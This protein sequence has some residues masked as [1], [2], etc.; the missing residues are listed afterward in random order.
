M[1][2]EKISFFTPVEYDDSAHKFREAVDNYFYLGGNKAKVTSIDTA[3]KCENVT[4]V[5]GDSSL[6]AKVLAVVKVVTYFTCIIPLVMLLAKAALRK[7]HQYTVLD[8]PNLNKESGVSTI[9]NVASNALSLPKE[10]EPSEREA[11]VPISTVAPAIPVESPFTGQGESAK[12]IAEPAQP[13]PQ[14]GPEP[15]QQANPM[16]V[17]EATK[18]PA[19][20]E[21]VPEKLEQPEDLEAAEPISED[22]EDPAA[23]S[24]REAEAR[25]ELEKEVD[26]AP[27]TLKKLQELLPK[28]IKYS[29]YGK[30]PEKEMLKEFEFYNHGQFYVVFKLKNVDFVFKIAYRKY[31]FGDRADLTAS[32]FANMVKAWEVCKVNNLAL[33]VIPHAKKLEIGDYELI[34]EQSLKIKTEESAQ[35][36]NYHKYSKELNET[37]RQLAIFVSKT[38]FKDVTW[39]NIP[40][41]EEA[42]GLQGRRVALIDLEYMG[43]AYYGFVGG[44]AGSR[45]LLRCISRE[46]IEIVRKEALKQG[47]KELEG[48]LEGTIGKRYREIES[49]EQL[50]AFYAKR[51]ISTG[52][53]PIR[54]D[55]E[56]LELGDLTKKE[57]VWIS[58]DENGQYLSPYIEK[59]VTLGEVAQDVVDE[60]NRLIQKKSEDESLKGKRYIHLDT[61]IGL[62]DAYRDL[63]CPQRMWIKDEEQ[64]QVWLTK[65]IKALHA[66]GYLF[67]LEKCSH[68]DYTIQA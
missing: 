19:P 36:E 52:K 38:G 31:S 41:I 62:M 61:Q 46:Q 8:D 20:I 17:L 14:E 24:L 58:K 26:L 35:E 59:E 15:L 42:Q 60:I 2:P 22:S 28:I 16:S 3:N 13:L 37:A 40:V 34:V 5:V 32:R 49:D 53:E 67:K 29:R 47:Y 43:D 63:G 27:E 64:D 65:I 45:G 11:I 57:T 25:K 39:R 7:N 48:E 4:L 6:L 68:N 21:T 54:V 51:G 50:R 12:P 55:I 33:L 30:T 10:K 23:I 44:F 9:Q 56:S 66:K 18:I 1:H